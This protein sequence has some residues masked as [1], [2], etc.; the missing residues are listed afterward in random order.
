MYDI[1]VK[2]GP[3]AGVQSICWRF[4]A[5]VDSTESAHTC[6]CDCVTVTRLELA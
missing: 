2:D 4:P 6:D 5:V 3:T 1:Y